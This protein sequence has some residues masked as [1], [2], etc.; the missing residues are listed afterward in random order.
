M[1][2][3]TTTRS[4]TTTSSRTTTMT[5]TRTRKPTTTKPSARP[6]RS[7]S[8]PRADR[9]PTAEDLIRTLG[10]E[11]HP[12]GGWFRETYRSPERVPRSALPGRFGGDRSLATTILYLLPAGEHSAFHRLRA[13]EIWCH[14]A[15]GPMHL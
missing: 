6:R 15:G 14:H 1:R 13:D 11:R 9:T 12:E 4:T 7:P 5:T 3:R 8:A 2:A 10:L